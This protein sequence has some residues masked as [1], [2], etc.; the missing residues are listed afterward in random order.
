MKDRIKQ[1][2]SESGLNQTKFAERIGVSLSAMQKIEYGTNNPS[3]QSIRAICSE[4]RVCRAWLTNGVGPMYLEPKTPDELIDEK[5]ANGS[6]FEKA[7]LR[8]ISRMSD[9][10]L[11]AVERLFVE[12][13]KEL[14]K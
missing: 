2:R 10:D 14:D 9:D 6:E 4:F 8:V 13:Q 11:A 3:E 1:V 7:L 5:L 12:M